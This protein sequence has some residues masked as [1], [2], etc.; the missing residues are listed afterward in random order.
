MITDDEA[1]EL[2]EEIAQWRALY[3]YMARN[4]TA[5]MYNIGN[6]EMTEDE[7]I[8]GHA[9]WDSGVACSSLCV[10]GGKAN[11]SFDTIHPND[12]EMMK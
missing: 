2:F 10:R 11:F 9:M 1:K 3:H 4:Q 6:V 8:A 12:M 5:L 7:L